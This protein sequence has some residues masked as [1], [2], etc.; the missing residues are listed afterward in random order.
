MM[1]LMR[2]VSDDSDSKT[3]PASGQAPDRSSDRPVSAL[4]VHFDKADRLAGK[5][6]RQKI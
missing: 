2:N 3:N 1:K 4:L 6:T 5:I